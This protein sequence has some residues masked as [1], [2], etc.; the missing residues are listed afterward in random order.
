MAVADV[1]DALRSKRCYK[2][3]IPHEESF[4]IIIKGSGTQFDPEVVSAFRDTHAQVT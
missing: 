2:P 1:Y 4:D 3:A